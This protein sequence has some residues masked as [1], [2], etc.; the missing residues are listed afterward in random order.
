MKKIILTTSFLLTGLVAFS[1]TGQ[2]EL[3]KAAFSI[4][5]TIGVAHSFMFPFITQGINL[6]GNYGVT[7]IYAPSNWGVGLDVRYSMEG[8]KTHTPEGTRHTDIDYIRVPI[9]AIYFM[10]AYDNSFRPKITLGPSLGFLA[11]ESDT[12]DGKANGFDA[13]INAS[14]GFNNRLSS[15]IWLNVDLNYYQGLMDVMKDTGATEMNGNIGLN[16]GLAFGL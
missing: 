14:I 9:K 10:G 16:L 8:S 6:V 5:P 7:A 4:G 1:Q 11:R 2:T 15:G 3:K 12:F 13:G